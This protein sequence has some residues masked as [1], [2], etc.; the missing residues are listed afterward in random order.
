M[1]KQMNEARGVPENVTSYAKLV[2]DKILEGL[3]NNKFKRKS[4][5]DSSI[6][7]SINAP[8]EFLKETKIVSID[9]IQVKINYDFYSSEQI[10]K[11]IKKNTKLNIK[12]DGFVLIGLSINFEVE[13]ELT[14]E[15]NFKLTKLTNPVLEIN[16]LVS[17]NIT[18]LEYTTH[19]LLNQFYD[20]SLSLIGHE[21]GHHVNMQAKG[22][23]DLAYRAKYAVV[24]N[25]RKVTD[26]DVLNDFVF[27]L[28]YLTTIENIV[29]PSEFKTFI[30]SKKITKK[31]FLQVYY[32]SEM[33]KKFNI[34]ENIT[35]DKLYNDIDNYLK[36]K[37]NPNFY[38]DNYKHISILFVLESTLIDIIKTGGEILQQIILEKMPN[39]SI[40][41]QNKVFS[42]KFNTFVKRHFFIKSSQNKK[43]LPYSELYLTNDNLLGS[44]DAEKT[45]K[46]IIK[47]MNITATKMKKKI[48][49]L[50]EDIPYEYEN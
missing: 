45:Y 3:K 12:S 6:F 14:K 18:Q 9:D 29:R 4:L 48:A 47:D 34:C 21:I 50:Y 44:I 41:K 7:T 40:A 25:P 37:L 42:K 46:A 17:Y 39:S 23:D 30:D 19:K 1:R 15:Y 49:K 2:F 28:Y 24:S 27:D 26:I 36:T 10:E 38:N 33:Y 20:S 13:D 22:E 32:D 31:Q 35:Y 43:P 16:F 5:F 11:I 8:I